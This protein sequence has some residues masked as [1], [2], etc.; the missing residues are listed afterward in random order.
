[1]KTDINEKMNSNIEEFLEFVNQSPTCYHAVSN[2]EMEL[3]KAGFMKL[4]EGE[5]WK[6][7]P[8]GSYYTVRND[9]SLIAFRMPRQD[10]QGFH[11]VAAHSDSPCFKL[12]ES[13]EITVEDH[14]VKMNVEKY[15]GMIMSTWMDRPLSVAG[16]I[17]IKNQDALLTK[18]VNIQK[19]L[20]IIPNVAI[21]MNKDMNKGIEYNAQI[22]MLPLLCDTTDSTTLMEMIASMEGIQKE[23]IL[24]SDLFLYAREK[25]RM[26]GLNQDYI[27][28]GR[29]DDLECA[30]T[31]IKS[32]IE[33]RPEQYLT[34]CAV[35]DNEEVGSRTRQGADS[36]LL[37]DAIN[38]IMLGSNKERQDLY[39]MI[40]HSFMIS[41]DNAHAV[42]PNHPEKSDPTNRPYLNDGIVIK[43]QGNQNYATDAGSAAK[44]K[45]L[46]TKAEV[47]YQTYA[48]R[49]DQPGGSTLGNIS[50]SHMSISTVD[51]GLAQLAMHSSYETAGSKD[52]GYLRKVLQ[53]FFTE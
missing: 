48:N 44:M 47:P 27:A 45:A 18:L 30:Y 4:S 28:S 24:G 39:C 7:E 19:D 22:D 26:L 33:S 13:P 46:C 31:G 42:H 12:K 50:T 37:E 51:I 52:I 10:Y 16:R 43:Y 34:I 32:L 1:M 11:I 23:Q 2:L 49:S 6:L 8:G 14:Y 21:H 17:V 36:S 20:L 29:L 9:S 25:G 41:A 3:K 35:F 53:T 40:D 38:R 5:I 15:G